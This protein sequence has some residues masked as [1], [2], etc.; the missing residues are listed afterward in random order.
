MKVLERSTAPL[1]LMGRIHDAISSLGGNANYC[2]NVL[3]T[4]ASF[5]TKVAIFS[6]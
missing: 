6:M 5:A 3:E 2:G 1:A 4:A